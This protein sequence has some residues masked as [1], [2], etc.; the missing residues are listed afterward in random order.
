MIS[1]NIFEIFKDLNTTIKETIFKIK[2][3]KN[4]ATEFARGIHNILTNDL[5]VEIKMNKT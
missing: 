4:F 3:T 2:K 5:F 1:K